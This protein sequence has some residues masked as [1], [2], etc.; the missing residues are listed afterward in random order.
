MQQNTKAMIFILAYRR[1]AANRSPLLHT[2]FI[3]YVYVYVYV[4]VYVY[5]VNLVY[6]YRNMPNTGVPELHRLISTE[7]S[8]KRGKRPPHHIVASYPLPMLSNPDPHVL[9]RSQAGLQNP[10]VKQWMQLV[11]AVEVLTSRGT[12]SHLQSLKLY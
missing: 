1:L 5:Y 10:I 7:I 8:D 4:V 3:S 12:I 11:L 9:G 2:N 6:K